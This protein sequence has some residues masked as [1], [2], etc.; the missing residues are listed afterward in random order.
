M[1]LVYSGTPRTYP[2]QGGGGLLAAVRF[3]T[4]VRLASVRVVPAG[5]VYPGGV[6]STTP[7]PF[8]VDVYLNLSPSDPINALAR[9]SLSIEPGAHALDFALDMPEGTTT[10]LV[11]VR[12]HAPGREITLSLYAHAGEPDVVVAEDEV[13]VSEA[14]D[15]PIPPTALLLSALLSPS[16]Q[17]LATAQVA[18]RTAALS[19]ADVLPRPD[20]LAALVSTPAAEGAVTSLLGLESHPDAR[21]ALAALARLSDPNTAAYPHTSAP[22]PAVLALARAQRDSAHPQAGAALATVLSHLSALL[23][24]ASKPVASTLAAALPQLAAHALAR[25]ADITLPRSLDPRSTLAALVPLLAGVTSTGLST[26]PAAAQLARPFVGQ[27]EPTDPLRLAWSSSTPSPALA[28]PSSEAVRLARALDAPAASSSVHFAPTAAE[29]VGLLAPV[30]AA[31]LGY[32]REPPLGIPST[33]PHVV[34]SG[35][36]AS[37]SDYAGKVYSAHEFRR[38]RETVSGLGVGASGVGRKASRHVDEFGR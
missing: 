17:A 31:T 18:A 33:L 8:P 2:E 38:E 5:V 6:G 10:R 34:A 22:L 23:D 16:T 13:A 24:T 3:S 9:T 20:V 35:A 15:L 1:T 14:T 36:A 27:L 12:L 30:Y 11:V 28:A 21:G 19:L 37:A 26:A 32:A 29:L 7:D 4:P 25:G